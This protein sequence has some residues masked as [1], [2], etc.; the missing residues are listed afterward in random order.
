MHLLAHFLG[1]GAVFG[2]VVGE[3]P[4][5]RRRLNGADRR[6][7]EKEPV[8]LETTEI[9]L[10]KRLRHGSAYPKAAALGKPGSGGILA[11]GRENP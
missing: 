3:P 9:G 11:P 10:G 1:Q 5:K 8:A 2:L 6:H 7:R 4:V